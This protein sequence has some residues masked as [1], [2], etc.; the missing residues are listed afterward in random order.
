VIKILYEAGHRPHVRKLLITVSSDFFKCAIGPSNSL[1]F[2]TQSSLAGTGIF[3]IAAAATAN[4]RASYSGTRNGKD[5]VK[6]YSQGAVR[7]LDLRRKQGTETLIGTDLITRTSQ[8]SLIAS[9]QPPNSSLALAY[10]ITA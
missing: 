2:G 3:P 1:L 7:G 5:T 8:S 4:S 6:L 9:A 10:N